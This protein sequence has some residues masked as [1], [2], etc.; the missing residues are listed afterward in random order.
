MGTWIQIVLRD[1]L[2]FKT[3]TISVCERIDS[4]NGGLQV[5]RGAMAQE[6]V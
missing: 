4:F 6:A 3:D 1:C 2:L 5:L